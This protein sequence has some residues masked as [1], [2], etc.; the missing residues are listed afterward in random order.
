MSH[1]GSRPLKQYSLFHKYSHHGWNNN[2]GKRHDCILLTT[3]DHAPKPQVTH[4]A[5]SMNHE[6]KM[7]HLGELTWK[8]C[9]EFDF[10]RGFTQSSVSL[11]I[12]YHAPK[13]W[14]ALNYNE[15]SLHLQP[16]IK[17]HLTVKSDLISPHEQNMMVGSVNFKV[18]SI[19]ERG[20]KT[21]TQRN[22]ITI[23][24]VIMVI[25]N[26]SLHHPGSG[27]P[28][29]SGAPLIWYGRGLKL[30]DHL[31]RQTEFIKSD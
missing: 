17:M 25:I 9:M 7:I 18:D 1:C 23:R 21:W 16:D 15:A 27:L 30:H 14:T 28:V 24:H 5:D 6:H 10:T 20:S 19:L 3:L 22:L 4:G 29:L 12:S 13:I 26:P 31:Q 8:R 2:P 11:F